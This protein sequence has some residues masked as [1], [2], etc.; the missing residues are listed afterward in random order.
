M[1]DHLFDDML[2]TDCEPTPKRARLTEDLIVST[3]D[4]HMT[5]L[6]P[7]PLPNTPTSQGSSP[8][9]PLAS[10]VRFELMQLAGHLASE[11]IPE[12]DTEL[13]SPTSAGNTAS[14][15]DSFDVAAELSQSEETE[16]EPSSA[17]DD[18][19]PKQGR[20]TT[21]PW[22]TEE[23]R[24]LLQAVEQLGPKRWSAVASCVGTRSGKQCRLR[25][26]NQID[27]RIKR[28]AWS[29]EEDTIILRE[30]SLPVPT[31]WVAIS[32]MLEGRPDNAIKNRWNSTLRRRQ[33]SAPLGGGAAP[34]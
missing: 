22:S 7:L 5:A 29:D 14:Q 17:T 4:N 32:G 23:D 10:P 3:S 13:G 25:W 31:S 18:Q 19:K 34:A 20:R 21:L 8:E 1:D 33:V 28:E 12:S 26:C 24:L 6:P 15:A 16:D 9:S 30:R 27:P 11:A 2:L